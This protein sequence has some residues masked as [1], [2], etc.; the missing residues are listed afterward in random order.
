MLELLT[1][2]EMAAADRITV[3][4]GTPGTVLMERAGAS[5]AA[6]ARRHWR[7]GPIVVLAGVGNNGGDGFVA[8]R[9]LRE[10]GHR[11][12][13]ALQGDRGRL[14]GEA[15]EAAGRFAGSVVAASPEVLAKAD[16]IIDALYGAGFRL[17]LP[18]EALAVVRAANASG[19]PVV[20]VDLPTGVD[21]ASGGVGEVAIRADETV[22]FFR[23]KPGHVLLPGRVHCGAVTVADIGIAASALTTI[24][25]KTF[26]NR[27][28][29][30]IAN[31]PRPA[32]DTHKHRRG[33]VLVLSGPVHATG[34]ARM[35]AIAALRAGAGLVTLA[36][37]PDALSVNAGHLT[38][39]MVAPMAGAAGLRAL[40]LDGRRNVLVAGPGLGVGE[41]SA[42]LVE[43]AL[44]SGRQIVLDAD[45]LTSFADDPP[46]LFAAIA[47]S[48]GS[49]VLT[50]HDGE[51]GSLF[52]ELSGSRL[53]RAR[54]AARR[55][56]ATILL[57]GPDT[58][59][60]AP[61]GMAAIADNAPPTLATAGSG[62]VLAGLVAG[63]RAQGMPAFGAA[64]AAV[65][66]HGEA[67]RALGPGLIAEDLP[68]AVPDVLARL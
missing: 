19:A 49:V 36:S 7:G 57:K 40:L 15:A 2:E 41:A 33:N 21:G 46:R 23:R 14:K 42:R 30:W 44:R 68:H 45:A 28:D 63:L 53:E 51:F 3:A 67:A 37:P 9:L 8:A 18:P 62:D 64:S 17:P 1:P 59:V 24:A 61:D 13:V 26:L 4:S 43:I 20:A 27:P 47:R 50:P 31:L 34:A 22:T 66:I 52:P 65:W 48:A 10:A 38:S 5:V 39:V 58:V 32:V 54:A 35:A 25:P 16:L 6:A 55:S 29:L 12:T 11:V 60:A 56:G